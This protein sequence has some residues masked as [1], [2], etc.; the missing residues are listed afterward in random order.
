MLAAVR[1]IPD[2]QVPDDD[3]VIVIHREGPDA[4]ELAWMPDD[5]H[6]CLA[7]IRYEGVTT[8]C[9][10]LPTS[11]ARVGIR[12]V[13]KGRP[14]P[15]QPGRSETRTVFF[16]VADG[17]HGPYHYT[18]TGEPGPGMGP[19]RDATAVFASG[20]TLSLLTYERPTVGLSPGDREICSADNAICF[21][22]L[23]VYVSQDQTTPPNAPAT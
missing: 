6:Y 3:S 12:L 5:R 10:P 19:I 14:Y 7:V 17:G 9:N 18:A 2:L 22:A 8:S 1:R 23:D 11:W 16:A 13:T 21:P 15:D 20:R 4:G